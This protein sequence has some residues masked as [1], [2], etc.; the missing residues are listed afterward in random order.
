MDS[1]ICPCR[2]SNRKSL[3]PSDSLTDTTKGMDIPTIS[4]AENF[5][6][7]KIVSTGGGSEDERSHIALLSFRKNRDEKGAM[8]RMG[9]VCS[10]KCP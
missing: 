2:V 6:Q 10:P 4:Y 8:K 1:L 3:V 7:V 5:L 9:D